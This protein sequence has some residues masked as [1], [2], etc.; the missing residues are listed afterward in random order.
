MA[1]LVKA[2]DEA[3]VYMANEM[4]RVY[5]LLDVVERELIQLKKPPSH[6]SSIRTIAR[7]KVHHP[8]VNRMTAL[9]YRSLFTPAVG[10]ES[11]NVTAATAAEDVSDS[12]ESEESVTP[13]EEDP[14]S[15]EFEEDPESIEFEE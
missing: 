5:E 8:D 1:S 10:G 15:V 13:V 7:K 14:E 3:Y 2:Q 9:K 6:P 12:E 11:S 4:E